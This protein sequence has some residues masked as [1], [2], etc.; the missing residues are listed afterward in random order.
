[1]SASPRPPHHTQTK[2]ADHD[3]DD[4]LAANQQTSLSAITTAITAAQTAIITAI[5]GAQTA[6]LEAIAG[7]RTDILTAIATARTDI[8]TAI[9][10]ARTDI[11]NAI[12]ALGNNIFSWVSV[13]KQTCLVSSEGWRGRRCRPKLC[14]SPVVSRGCH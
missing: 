11:L 14:Q 13:G 5:G 2:E 7:A 6:I 12:T 9:A 10:N 4:D 3:N 1:V 8:L